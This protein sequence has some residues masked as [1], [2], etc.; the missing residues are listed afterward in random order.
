MLC[1]YDNPH[2][3]EIF[4]YKLR[5]QFFFQFEIIMNVFEYYVTGLRS[6]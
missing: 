1:Y 5:D 6:L 2:N 3:D 4:L